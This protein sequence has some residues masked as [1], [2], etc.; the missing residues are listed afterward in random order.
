MRFFPVELSDFFTKI[1]TDTIKYRKTNNYVRND[2]LQLMIELQNNDKSITSDI[3][4]A[5]CF[6]FFVAGFET[7]STAMTFALY[8]LASNQE[9]QDKVRAE[10]NSVLKE[11]D[12]K[13]TYD[14]MMDMKYLGQVIDGELIYKKTV[15]Y[16]LERLADIFGNIEKCCV[17]IGVLNKTPYT[18]Q[19][20]V[21]FKISVIPA[22]FLF[23]HFCYMNEL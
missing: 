19:N 20:G 21:F 13:I 14:S 4:T 11:H 23:S 22:A 9:I 15:L 8:E 16:L 10:I 7:S 2:F 5:Q 1:V 18:N 12:G 6:V 3:I 17:F